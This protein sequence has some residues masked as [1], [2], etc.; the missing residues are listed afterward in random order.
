MEEQTVKL[1][2]VDD[3]PLALLR[4]RSF[5][6][7]ARG[8]EI[9]GEAENGLQALQAVER[10]KPDIV[11]TDI[12]MPVMDGLELLKRLQ[13]LPSPPKVV[14]LTCYEDFEKVQ[15]ALRYGADDYLTKVLLSEDEF[16]GVLQR[17][18]GTLRKEKG[19][20]EQM[21]RLLLQEL[22][23]FPAGQLPDKLKQ[24]GF[25][26]DGYALSVI[27]TAGQLPDE[28]A[29]EWLAAAEP[30]P[31]FRYLAIR[32]APDTWCLFF[33]SVDRESFASFYGWFY[34]QCGRIGERLRCGFAAASDVL[35]YVMSVGGV[36]HR[37]S[38]MHE[39]Y[40]RG[41]ALCEAGFYAMPGELIREP[42]SCEYEPLPPERFRALLAA[43]GDAALRDDGQ[44]AGD[45]IREWAGLIGGEY[46]PVPVQVRRMAL[47]IAAQ[48]ESFGWE[49]NADAEPAWPLERFKQ[50][51][52]SAF[53]AS[54]LACEAR[55]L[56]GL[57]AQRNGGHTGRM[58]KEIK[59]ALRLIARDYAQIELANAARQVNLSPSWFAALFRNETGKSFHDYVQ[60]CRLDRAKSLLRT[61]DMKVY[62]VAD[63]VGI[64]NSRYFSRLFSEYAGATPL[65]YRK[66]HQAAR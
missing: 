63:S 42:E 31:R 34:E 48:L 49:K 10:L 12:G 13:T 65:D 7:A 47:L 15:V 39:A 29:E 45:R 35:D 14:L 64:P 24:A 52:E 21:V 22:L 9:A 36:Y 33:Y 53:H 61:T 62:E 1:L 6:L 51:A 60:D 66:G 43:I 17:T 37:T 23:L 3:E 25:T 5:G 2:L 20:A 19:D 27:R 26:H 58:R 38:D 46:R 4:L 8:F 11:V 50:A 28:A 56:A 16:V 44:E 57:M 59:E 18:A 55:Q 54:V 41:T 32:M 30:D 40:S